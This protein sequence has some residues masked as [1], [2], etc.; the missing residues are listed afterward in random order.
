MNDSEI[1]IVEK[2]RNSRAIS[3][4]SVSFQE[5]LRA[6]IPSKITTTSS[7]GIIFVIV[8]CQRVH[9]LLEH[10]SSCNQLPYLT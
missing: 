6:Q 1:I 8:T 2:L 7:Q 3:G 10:I 4:K 9:I 5:I